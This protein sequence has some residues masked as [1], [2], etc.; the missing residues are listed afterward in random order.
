MTASVILLFVL[1]VANFALHRAVLESGHP[2]V[3]QAP[4]L[5]SRSGV[6]ISLGAEFLVLLGCMLMAGAGVVWAWC[7]VAYSLF[8]GFSGWLI[9]SRRI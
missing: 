6:R 9:L 5:Q 2:L 8:N 7:Y 3:R 1:G 4:W